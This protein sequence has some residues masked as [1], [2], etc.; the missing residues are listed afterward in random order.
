MTYGLGVLIDDNYYQL[1]SHLNKSTLALDNE[2]EEKVTFTLHTF[3]N[4]IPI[5]KFIV[6]NTN[7]CLY[8]YDDISSSSS[9]LLF[10]VSS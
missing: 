1:K 4:I 7:I 9:C 8:I 2:V 6:I 10:I 3:K 5:L